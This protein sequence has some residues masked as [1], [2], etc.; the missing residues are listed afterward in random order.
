MGHSRD[1]QFSL[2]IPNPGTGQFCPFV[3]SLRSPTASWGCTGLQLARA[4]LCEGIL[5]MKLQFTSRY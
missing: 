1:V 5:R 4:C 2:C 3:G